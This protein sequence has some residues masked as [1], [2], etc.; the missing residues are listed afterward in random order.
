MEMRRIVLLLASMAL[1]VIW[2]SG[3]ALADSPTTKEDCKNGGYKDFGFKN[4]G[5]CI[6]AVKNA[7][8]ADT[9]A[10]V[11]TQVEG[12][13]EGELYSGGH[14]VFESNEPVSFSYD[15]CEVG[16]TA[17]CPNY[18]LYDSGTLHTNF[19]IRYATWSTVDDSPMVFYLKATD[20]AG[21][22]TIVERRYTQE[23]TTAP[24]INTNGIQHVPGD[25]TAA[26]VTFSANEPATFECQLQG[27]NGSTGWEPCTSPMVYEN[28]EAGVYGFT[29]RATD[30]SGNMTD[31]VSEIHH[32]VVFIDPEAPVVSI[33][34][35][36]AEGEVVNTDSVSF[37]WTAT[38]NMEVYQVNCF[39]IYSDGGGRP[40]DGGAELGGSICGGTNSAPEW[41]YGNPA[42]F[43]DLPDG[44]TTFVI[45]AIDRGGNQVRLE[46]TFTVDSPPVFNLPDTLGPF[47][48]RSATVEWTTSEPVHSVKCELYLNQSNGEVVQINIDTACSTPKTYQ[49]INPGT[50]TFIV[51]GRDSSNQLSEPYEVQFEV[52]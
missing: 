38:D 36:P 23:D 13:A 14:I 4:Q 44:E 22:T 34:S 51:S 3:V 1:A 30:A 37:S 6:E 28:L 35:G 40:P 12:P 46:R 41:D 25:P 49:G 43:S 31:D 16:V 19:E 20:A 27:P 32:S 42:T 39:I 18:K 26:T 9:T 21:N 52:I 17:V 5:E 2:G 8:P 29:L 10:P 7:P 45:Q 48:N 50:Y 33:D 47:E 24:V 11:L 15:I